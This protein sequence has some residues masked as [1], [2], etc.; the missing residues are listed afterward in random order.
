MN[1][2]EVM[3]REK[4]FIKNHID[5][6]TAT[7][8]MGLKK[9]SQDPGLL[10]VLNIYICTVNKLIKGKSQR[11]TWRIESS[12]KIMKKRLEETF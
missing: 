7:K 4:P 8:N 5:V 10:T 2:I 1:W 3:C 12:E 11:L 9:V 6:W